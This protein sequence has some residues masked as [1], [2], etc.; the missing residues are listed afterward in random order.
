[1]KL[2]AIMLGLALGLAGCGSGNGSTAP[3]MPVPQVVPAPPT[4]LSPAPGATGVSPSGLTVTISYDP[5]GN[6]TLRLVDGSGATLT[7]GAFAPAPTGSGQPAGSAVASAP[8]LAA[9]TTYTVFVDAV[10]PPANPCI[11]DARSG[12]TSF[13]LGSFTTS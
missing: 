13:Q 12:A 3:C 9:R 5:A 1:M 4:L 8:P 10:Y 7:G 2:F 6:G 11:Q